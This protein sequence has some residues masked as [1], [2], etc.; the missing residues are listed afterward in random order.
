MI[1]KDDVV[2]LR[3]IDENDADVLMSLINDPE[4]ESSVMGWS[5][6]VSLLDQK[7][8]DC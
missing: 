7:K 5:Y 2:L 1:L 4:V 6:P 3:A 8:V